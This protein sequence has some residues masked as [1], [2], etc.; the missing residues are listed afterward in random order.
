MQFKVDADQVLLTL[1][2]TLELTSLTRTLLQ[3]LM[4]EEACLPHHGCMVAQ[5]HRFECLL[6]LI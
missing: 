1:D 4:V 3:A 2:Q 5:A 6:I